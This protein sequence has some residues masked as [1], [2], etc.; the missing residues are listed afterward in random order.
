MILFI[1]SILLLIIGI[2]IIKHSVYDFVGY[3]IVLLS[4]SC[5]GIYLASLIVSPLYYN[6]LKIKGEQ[7]SY[8]IQEARKT[9]NNIELA[10]I[11][12]KITNYNTELQTAKYYN[13]LFLFDIFYDDKITQ[14]EC[15][16]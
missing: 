1:V 10:T 5:L 8:S 12:V 4:F 2:R 15:V 16:K 3:M 13:S 7:L 9:S 14:L 11:T 6:E